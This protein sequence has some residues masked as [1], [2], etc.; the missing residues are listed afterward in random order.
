MGGWGKSANVCRQVPQP[1]PTVLSQQLSH[2]PR[3]A[4]R[5]T[6]KHAAAADAATAVAAAAATRPPFP[7]SLASSLS[8]ARSRALPHDVPPIPTIR[9]NLSE[10]T[11]YAPHLPA[12]LAAHADLYLSPDPGPV[13]VS[14]TLGLM[15][16]RMATR[17]AIRMAT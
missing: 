17:M 12:N 14:L 4:S 6:T 2:P 15:A 10:S 1:R 16:T 3:P 8:Y 13:Q 9:V 5:P 11:H 7:R